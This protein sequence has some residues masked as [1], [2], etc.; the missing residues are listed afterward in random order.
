MHK[1]E[2]IFYKLLLKKINGEISEAETQQ[3]INMLKAYPEF[4]EAYDAVQW[5]WQ[6]ADVRSKEKPGDRADKL[7]EQHLLKM[8]AAGISPEEETA[9]Q[10]PVSDYNR[11]KRFYRSVVIAAVLTIGVLAGILYVKQRAALPAHARPNVVMTRPGSRSKL[12]LPD[13]T[14]VWLNANSRLS[15]DD[16]FM[17]ER[18]VQL[19]GEAF[20]DVVKD[21]GRPFIINTAVMNVKVLGTRF[22][23]RSYEGDRKSE[24]VLITGKIEVQVKIRPE[25]RYLLSPYEKLSLIDNKALYRKTETA[26]STLLRPAKALVISSVNIAGT[27][28]TIAE[29]AWIDNKLVFGGES[30]A[31]LAIRMERWFGASITIQDDSLQYFKVSGSFRDESLED[32]L[33]ALCMITGC[34]YKLKDQTAVLYY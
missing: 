12:I 19:D 3:L 1:P 29:T 11:R 23:L 2:S 34:K 15:Y 25:E 26:S 21:A 8:Y 22:N 28:S 7:W 9:V 6:D 10:Q 20:F 17:K 31:E 24:A 27:D 33:K 5:V 18:T 4:S 13:G 14:T 16:D 32:A 30:L